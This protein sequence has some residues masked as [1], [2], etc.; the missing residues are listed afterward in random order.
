MGRNLF[1]RVSAVTYSEEAVRKSWPR[2]CGLVWPEDGP[3]APSAYVQALMG[4]PGKGVMELAHALAE[5]QALADEPIKTQLAPFAAKLASLL[6]D[7][8]T[9]LGDR[10]AQA[11][12]ALA[13]NVEDTLDDA[14]KAL[15]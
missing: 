15:S 3:G 12:H 13:N 7:M 6:R 8:E 10:N 2:L 5:G 14:E 4:M 1:I 11:A 9:A